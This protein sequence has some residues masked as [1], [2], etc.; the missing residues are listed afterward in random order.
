MES[1]K[2]IVDVANVVTGGEV[3]VGKFSRIR[4]EFDNIKI[5]TDYQLVEGMVET[6]YDPN[7]SGIVD[8]DQAIADIK[9]TLEELVEM[10]S[11]IGIDSTTRENIKILT[12]MLVQQAQEELPQLIADK[13]QAATDKINAAK[14]QYDTALANG[15]QELADQAK[16][17]FKAAQDDLKD[18]EKEKD[19]FLDAYASI[20]KE[21]LK[22][23][24]R[25]SDNNLKNGLNQYGEENIQITETGETLE[26]DGTGLDQLSNVLQPDASTT[27]ELEQTGNFEYE[28]WNMLNFIATNLQ[29]DEGTQEL[30][31]LLENEG[32][33]LGVYIYNRLE[34]GAKERDLVTEIKELIIET[35]TEKIA[36]ST[37][38]F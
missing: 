27:N 8:L 28:R 24:V 7:W 21:A 10:L 37:K 19:D 4:V 12:E 23:I 38:L 29:T 20:I 1:I 17:D 6:S 26:L 13:I 11:N 36:L 18:A 30:G 5:N 33:K 25:E 3:N 31:G 2:E 16:D 34:E 15:N 22:E 9:M 32:E 35:I 14:E